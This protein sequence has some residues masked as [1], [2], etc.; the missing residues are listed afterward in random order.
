MLF[1]LHCYK[2]IGPKMFLSVGGGSNPFHS[3]ISWILFNAVP[4][5]GGCSQVSQP[6][7]DDW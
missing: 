3:G 4:S 6:A 1:L 5:K 7:G 2:E